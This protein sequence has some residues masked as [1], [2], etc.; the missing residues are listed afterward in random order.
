MTKLFP[1]AP[2]VGTAMK[3]TQESEEARR[4]LALRR[5]ANKAFLGEPGPNPQTLN[6]ILTAATRVPD[7][8][9]LSP[10]RFI[11]LEG[12]AR[13]A[14]AE[15]AARVQ[16]EENEFA[17]DGDLDAT[18]A[19]PMRAPTVV[20]LVSSPKDDNR[21]PV[22]EQELS[23]GA[24]GHNLLLSAN[25]AGFAGCWLTEWISFSDGINRVLGLE[26]GERIAGYFYL[27][28][29]T[30]DPQERARPDANALISRWTG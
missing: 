4:F 9:R 11:V 15:K 14:F 2:P 16:R 30:A 20:V 19:L 3:A 21:T 1:D 5:S 7:H 25:A 23:V 18:R 27:G 17:S 28:T 24:L 12:E 6:D 29:A 26:K 10:W 13:T 22:W 8:R